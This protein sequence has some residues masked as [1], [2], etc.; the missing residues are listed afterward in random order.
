MLRILAPALVL[1]IA[2]VQLAAQTPEAHEDTVTSPIQ[3]RAEGVVAVLRGET[4]ASEVFSPH[5]LASVP[6]ERL[7]ALARQLT[8]QFGPLQGLEDATP[9]GPGAATIAIRYERALARG[10]MQLDGEGMVAGLLLN[11][12]DPIDDSAEKIAADLAALP[13]TVGVYYAPLAED[14]EPIIATNADA[15]FAIGSTFKLYVLSA[16]ARQVAAGE[17][18]WDEVVRLDT[19]SLPS[20]L[21]QD[22]PKGAPV[23]LHT[24]ATLM[25]SISDNTATDQLIKIVG[26]DA[27]AEELRASGHSAPAKT[28]PFLTTLELFGLKGDLA[29]GQA[30]AATGEEEQ[31]RLIEAFATEIAGDPDKIVKPTFTQPTAIDSLEWFASGRD[32]AGLLRR[33]AELDDAAAREIMA[34]T[35]AVPEPK[36]ADWSYIGYKGGSEPGVLN[37]TWLLQDR[38]GEWRILTISWNNPAAPVDVGT[39]ELL[40]QRILSLE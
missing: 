34:V 23:T 8:A 20:G 37:L 16:L 36:R 19:R 11:Q 40:A 35:P 29:R 24:L 5:F 18:S 10:P 4:A 14:A 28:L 33:I 21:S 26:R 15:Q 2:P 32:L 31:A 6:E 38:A 17:R 1:A 27:V 22:W 30:Y 25:I 3:A 12:F 13:G 39:L 7:E 9:T